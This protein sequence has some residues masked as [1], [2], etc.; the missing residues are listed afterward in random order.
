MDSN[1]SNYQEVDQSSQ[2]FQRKLEKILNFTKSS[3]LTDLTI[4]VISRSNSASSRTINVNKNVLACESS[5]F[6]QQFS[7]NPR[8]NKIKI[9]GIR[10]EIVNKLLE[11]FYTDS[12]IINQNELKEIIQLAKIFQLDRVLEI[13]FNYIK[14]NLNIENAL[15]IRDLCLSFD[16]LEIVENCDEFVVNHFEDVSKSQT[17]KQIKF[18]YLEQLIKSDD[19][20]VRRIF[21]I[22]V[23]WIEVDIQNRINKGQKLLKA[24]R[25]P[26][27]PPEYLHQISSHQIIKSRKLFQKIFESIYFS[28][29]KKFRMDQNILKL[30]DITQRK[31]INSCA[32]EK[33][34]CI[35]GFDDQLNDV[36]SIEICSGIGSTGN[37]FDKINTG[38]SYFACCTYKNNIILIG[39]NGT[40]NCEVDYSGT[41]KSLISI[42]LDEKNGK[43]RNRKSSSESRW[44]STGC[45]VNDK[46]YVFGG[47]ESN[48]C[49]CYCPQDDSWR[50]LPK[51][52]EE[53]WWLGY[54]ETR[55][56]LTSMERFDVENEQWSTLKSSIGVGRQG[57]TLTVFK[58][59]IILIGG[60][61]KDDKKYKTIQKY[62]SISDS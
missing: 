40:S 31:Y 61:D 44:G 50:S 53:R 8:L 49:E 35:G 34:I 58:N 9:C 12:I 57:L 38:R 42:N 19:L 18:K 39:G 27:M 56:S 13:A 62:D 32:N 30:D 21:E 48:S 15:G 54:A 2:R 5:Y 22:V 3:F 11:Y 41:D 60:S 17:F 6:Q 28:T 20:V 47:I 14:D 4:E 43:W 52:K 36:K 10:F 45:S 46:F 24:V 1:T 25:F 55:F 37:Q 51:M 59:Q 29:N 26:L 16:Q 23:Q 7:V 33:L